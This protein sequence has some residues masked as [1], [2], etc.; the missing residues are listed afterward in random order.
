MRLTN[1]VKRFK[2]IKSNN[3]PQ[4]LLWESDLLCANNPP[5]HF[6]R[7]LYLFADTATKVKLVGLRQHPSCAYLIPLWLFRTAG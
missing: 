3:T 5:Q 1:L 2:D 4:E 7:I 6:Q